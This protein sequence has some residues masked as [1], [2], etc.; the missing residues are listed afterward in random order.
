MEIFE[1]R[2]YYWDNVINSLLYMHIIG[3]MRI[4]DSKL[5]KFFFTCYK[6]YTWKLVIKGM[7]FVFVVGVCLFLPFL[8]LI[9]VLSSKLII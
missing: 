3:K 8:L 2:M 1:W 5:N 7:F 6:Y 9:V 4:K